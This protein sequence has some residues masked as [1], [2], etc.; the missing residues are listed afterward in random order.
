[1]TTDYGTDLSCTD[2]FAADFHTVTGR[3]VLSEACVRRL[4][5]R[6]GLLRRHPM[7]GYDVRDELNND[8]SS[9]DIARIAANVNSQILRDERIVSCSCIAALA[10]DGTLT[11]TITLTDGAGPFAL[12]LSVSDATVQIVGGTP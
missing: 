11:L 4:T 8:V 12:V 10:K 5:T 3:R 9:T 2:D 6:L 7:Y 1:M